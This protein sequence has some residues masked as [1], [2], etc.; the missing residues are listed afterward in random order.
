MIP[1]VPI[2]LAGS[3]IALAAKAGVHK[4]VA[5]VFKKVDEK[6]QQF[7]EKNI[8]SQFVS[9]ERNQQLQEFIHSILNLKKSKD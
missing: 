7:F 6:Y 4:R 8:D 3:G 5:K 2:L 9:Q 1:L